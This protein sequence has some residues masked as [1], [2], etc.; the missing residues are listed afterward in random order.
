MR[1]MLTP[2]TQAL[3]D[4]GLKAAEIN[5]VVLVGG[6]TRMPRVQTL[7]RE[8]FREG[9]AR[10]ATFAAAERLFFVCAAVAHEASSSSSSSIR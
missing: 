7:V 5:E 10:P 8:I 2:C 6:M 3:K 9:R 1:N 4:A